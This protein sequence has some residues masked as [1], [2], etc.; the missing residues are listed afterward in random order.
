MSFRPQNSSQIN[1]YNHYQD[2]GNVAGPPSLTWLS[3]TTCVRSTFAWLQRSITRTG[4]PKG[5]HYAVR[6]LDMTHDDDDD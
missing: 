2:I 6:P 1:A 3:A 4:R 5:D